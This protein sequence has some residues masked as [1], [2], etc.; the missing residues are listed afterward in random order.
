MLKCCL[1]GLHSKQLN[2]YALNII[3][4]ECTV[5]PISVT[6]CLPPS[7]GLS[8]HPAP[9]D[10]ACILLALLHRIEAVNTRILF[11]F[12]HPNLLQCLPLLGLMASKQLAWLKETHRQLGW[13]GGKFKNVTYLSLSVW[14]SLPPQPMLC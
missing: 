11:P 10:T 2:G 1:G 9:Q 5:A 4:S 6:V 13:G 14:L 7:P 3:G 12:L 8:G